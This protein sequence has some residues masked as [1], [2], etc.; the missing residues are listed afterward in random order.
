LWVNSLAQFL[1]P[2]ERSLCT[3]ATRSEFVPELFVQGIFIENKVIQA[4]KRKDEIWKRVVP[5]HQ[6][7]NGRY[8]ITIIDLIT[9]QVKTFK[10][11]NFFYVLKKDMLTGHRSGAAQIQDDN[12]Y[13]VHFMTSHSI[14]FSVKKLLEQ[15]FSL[16]TT[17]RLPFIAEWMRELMRKSLVL[18]K[19]VEKTIAMGAP[20]AQ[21]VFIN[22]PMLRTL[23][24][25]PAPASGSAPSNRG[26]GSG[27]EELNILLAAAE[28]IQK[29]VYIHVTGDPESEAD[30]V[31]QFLEGV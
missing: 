21:P 2:S 30:S 6:V 28:K 3:Y 16:P 15:I 8:P 19:F 17:L 1:L 25:L 9:R 31:I 29:G 10:L 12:Y 11:F 27:D 20:N 14:V 4:S 22:K 18:S 23:L 26:S 13:K 5:I 7:L 24:D